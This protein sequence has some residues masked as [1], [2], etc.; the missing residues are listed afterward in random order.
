MNMSI[1]ESEN[2]RFI[3]R[4][5]SALDSSWRGS[6]RSRTAMAGCRIHVAPSIPAPNY[7]GR[8]SPYSLNGRASAKDRRVGENAAANV[9]RIRANAVFLTQSATGFGK[10]GMSPSAPVGGTLSA[11]PQL[12]A[13]ATTL[14]HVAG[15]PYR[16]D[17]LTT[18]ALP[19]AARQIGSSSADGR[20][21][22]TRR[23]S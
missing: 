20:R 7:R 18:A 17:A 23:H 10:T 22:G 13:R 19:T 1:E 12:S 15:A 9:E 2:P 14:I 8:P 5:I 6:R 11:S 3:G 21:L 16:R 4:Q